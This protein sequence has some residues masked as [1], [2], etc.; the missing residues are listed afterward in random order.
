[1]DTEPFDQLKNAVR[2]FAAARSWEPFHTPKNLAMALVVEASELVQLF[3][4][5]TPDE[6]AR[7]SE[8]A[9][10]TAACAE[11]IADVAIY[12]VRLADVAGINITDAINAKMVRNEE[13]FPVSAEEG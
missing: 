2:E 8:D 9:E 13:R 10:L 11:E 3:Q 7:T 6:S 12:L 5:M 4:W 1:M